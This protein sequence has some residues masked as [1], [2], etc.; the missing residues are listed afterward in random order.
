[1][2]QPNEIQRM[3]YQHGSAIDLSPL[4][5][6]KFRFIQHEGLQVLHTA[7]D[8]EESSGFPF[9]VFC[10]PTYYQLKVGEW[11]KNEVYLGTK[12]KVVRD[13]FT[14]TAKLLNGTCRLELVCLE[15]DIEKPIKWRIMEAK[16][17]GFEESWGEK[18]PLNLM[19][20]K[21]RSTQSYKN[22][23]WGESEMQHLYE[24]QSKLM[25]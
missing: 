22:S 4:D 10:Y 16:D 14:Q 21:K 2:K 9:E 12:E 8:P 1:M 24:M 3:I 13:F 7:F 15:D 25:K 5:D 19:F 20:W 23:E 18:G 6:N 17:N 11:Y